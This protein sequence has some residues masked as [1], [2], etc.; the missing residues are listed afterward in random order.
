MR[1]A[2][3]MR[4]KGSVRDQCSAMLG[5]WRCAIAN[6]FYAVDTKT[7]EPKKIEP[8]SAPVSGTNLVLPV[9]FLFGMQSPERKPEHRGVIYA[10]H[11][12]MATMGMA[13]NQPRGR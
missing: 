9:G 4:Y 7:G 13:K 3:H 5:C 10:E 11:S 8:E 1:I 12:K 6:P 2:W